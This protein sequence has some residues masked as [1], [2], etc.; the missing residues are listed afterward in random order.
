VVEA[1]KPYVDV[2]TTNYDRPDW[3]NGQLPLYYLERLHEL[4]DKPILVT[5]YYVAAHENR[6]SNKNTDNV[7]TTVATQRDRAVALRHRLTFFASLPY[8]VGAHWFQYS[9]EPT[10][11]RPKDGE[12]YNFGLVDIE[13]RPYEELCAAFKKVHQDITRLHASGSAVAAPADDEPMLIPMVAST[14]LDGIGH[15]NTQRAIVRGRRKG[16]RNADL[17]ASWNREGLYL[18]VACCQYVEPNAYSD[19]HSAEDVFRLVWRISVDGQTPTN[20]EFGNGDELNVSKPALPCR[21]R[22]RGIRYTVIAKLPTVTIGRNRLKPGDRLK[23][24][25]AL[26]DRQLGNTMTWEREL[27]CDG[28][29]NDVTSQLKAHSIER[30]FGRSSL[31]GNLMPPLA[32]TAK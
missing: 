21:L 29:G 9:D 3:T 24:T 6:S 16:P 26:I 19:E 11:G 15:W 32:Y 5:E 23:L 12:D 27:Q 4:S 8:V 20:V 31:A 17:L 7:F 25:A 28:S 22:Q 1:A 10:R 30:Q 18:A 2:L 14:A 13:D